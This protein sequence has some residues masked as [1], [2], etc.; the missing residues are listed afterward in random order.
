MLRKKNNAMVIWHWAEFY[1][2]LWYQISRNHSSGKNA[3]T[4]VS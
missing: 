2:I 4:R 3:V 1:H